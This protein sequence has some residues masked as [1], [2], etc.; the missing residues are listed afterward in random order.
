[1]NAHPRL[2]FAALILST[3]IGTQG[4]SPLF[5]SKATWTSGT[6]HCGGDGNARL[7][8]AD[9][10][11][12]LDIVTSAPGPRRWVIYTNQGGRFSQQP[13]WNSIE[14]S[15]CDHIS[16]L[17][18]NGDGLADLAATHESH[19]TL[20]INQPARAKRPFHS[21]PDWE[22]GIYIDANQIV[23]GDYDQDGDQDMLM[24]AGLPFLG[25]ALFENRS[26]FPARLPT[27]RI[28]LREYSEASI[29]ADFDSDGDLDI[30]ASYPKKGT[31]YLHEN[32]EGRFRQG[33]LI[34]T[35]DRV[36]HVQRIYC[37]DLDHDG[38]KEVICAKGPW[39][40]PGASVILSQQKQAPTLREIWRSDTNT[41]YH[42]FAF[43]DLDDDGDLD[44]AG[45]DWRGRRVSV[46]LQTNGQFPVVPDWKAATK[47]PGHEVALGDIDA[48][49][50]LDLVAGCLDQAY[51]FKNR[52]Q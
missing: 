11:G 20:Y 13:D 3:A 50:D 39:G 9:Q 26:G 37:L 1:M 49:G 46:Y 19:C 38:S 15:D 33:R 32:D 14:T 44:I 34:F 36:R 35:D 31:I 21:K 6:R 43:G 10:D 42:G 16:V 45:A 22:T 18:F 27:Q 5:D 17:D 52:T 40:P 30:L 47:G 4:A 24:A 2:T 8:D 7:I 29:F 28:G 25:L 48:D 23:F 51:L 41:G 12:D